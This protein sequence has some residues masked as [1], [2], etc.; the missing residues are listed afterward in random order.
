ML[1]YADINFLDVTVEHLD[2]TIEHI[3]W[4]SHTRRKMD[5]QLWDSHLI[6]SIVLSRRST[7]ISKI[8]ISAYFSILNITAEYLDITTKYIK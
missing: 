8:L 2:N 3:R 4:L 6:C 1:K 7:V 5:V